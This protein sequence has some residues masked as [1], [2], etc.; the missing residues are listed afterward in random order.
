MFLLPPY[1]KESLSI[2]CQNWLAFFIN[3][4]LTDFVISKPYGK[5]PLSEHT[6]LKSGFT[7]AC[8]WYL[9]IIL[10]NVLGH[11][12]VLSSPTHIRGHAH[13]F[14]HDNFRKA[15]ISPNLH[16]VPLESD[17]VLHLVLSLVS[18]FDSF[19]VFWVKKAITFGWVAL[20]LILSLITVMSTL[21]C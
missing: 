19:R 11:L 2:K 13:T 5:C 3:T 6:I 8:R 1:L 18:T 17:I 7:S 12:L 20:G 10:T 4:P 9:I 16:T 21:V 14:F 15:F